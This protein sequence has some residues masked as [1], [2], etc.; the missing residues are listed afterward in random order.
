M[1]K[2]LR[3][4]IVLSCLVCIVS[5]FLTGVRYENI[6]D[7]SKLVSRGYLESFIFLVVASITLAITLL[8]SFYLKFGIVNRAMQAGTYAIIGSI[9]ILTLVL[10]YCDYYAVMHDFKWGESHIV[11][12]LGTIPATILFIVGVF[13]FICGYD[14][15]R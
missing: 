11:W 5:S 6:V 1:L 7:G 8:L 2:V 15:A 12:F 13:V 9:I 3:Y 4:T 10:V 14:R